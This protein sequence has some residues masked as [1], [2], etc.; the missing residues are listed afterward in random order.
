MDNGQQTVTG[1]KGS[2]MHTGSEGPSHRRATV[3]VTA[4]KCVRV[5]MEEYCRNTQCIPAGALELGVEEADVL[6]S[7]DSQIYFS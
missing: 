4:G 5:G 1:G 7:G 6:S 2:L 3:A